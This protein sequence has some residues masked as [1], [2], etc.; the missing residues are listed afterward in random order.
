[1]VIGAEKF[2]VKWSYDMNQFALVDGVAQRMMG[3]VGDLQPEIIRC[4]R[5]T[6]PTTLVCD[7]V[8]VGRLKWRTT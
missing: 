3:R 5:S 1:M 6:H 7:V 2:Q 8:A 4:L